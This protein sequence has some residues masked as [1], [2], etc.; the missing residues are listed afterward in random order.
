MSTILAC[1]DGS[2]YSGSICQHTAWIATKMN[3]SVHVLHVIERSEA[4]T[5]TDLS[6]NLGFDASNELLEELVSADEANA[7]VAR[8]RSKALLQDAAR[9]LTETGIEVMTTQRHGSLVETLEEFEEQAEVLVIGKRGEHADFAKGHLGSNL[10]RVVRTAKIPVLVASRAFKPIEKV[11]IA[12]DSGASAL[13]AV[14]YVATEPLLQGT[15]IHLIAIGKVGSSLERG[16][17]TAATGLRSAGFTI[18]QANFLQGDVED[19]IASEVEQRGVDL[20]V[21]GAYG[22]S[23]IRQMIIGSTTTSLIRTCLVPILLFR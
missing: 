16:L 6:G 22:H 23:K 8:L 17:E 11:M 12:F 1:T 15:K 20:L 4:D 3:A 7:R 9:Q 5:G 14:H 19:I 13:K 18:V 21:M 10:E 2:Q